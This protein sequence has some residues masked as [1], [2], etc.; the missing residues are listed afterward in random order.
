MGKKAAFKKKKKRKGVVLGS[1]LPTYCAKK[2]RDGKRMDGA[3]S[4]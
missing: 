1:I 3:T 2:K 4:C